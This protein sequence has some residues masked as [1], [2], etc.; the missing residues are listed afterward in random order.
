MIVD[1]HHSKLSALLF[2]EMQ[3]SRLQDWLFCLLTRPTRYTAV[4]MTCPAADCQHVVNNVAVSSQSLAIIRNHPSVFTK[5]TL[6][7]NLRYL[8]STHGTAGLA[9]FAAALKANGF[10]QFISFKRQRGEKLKNNA[11]MESIVASLE[12][13]VAN[14]AWI[15]GEE[16]D[17]EDEETAAPYHEE[18]DDDDAD[19]DDADD[20]DDGEDSAAVSDKDSTELDNDARSGRED[21][22]G[23][24]GNNRDEL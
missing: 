7:L 11:N 6:N 10:I 17:N 15:N 23:S 3:D 18:Y 12:E 19:D 5:Y 9:A 8:H 21:G 14:S 20:D 22:N 1:L 2:S 4:N 24:N 16:D 13:N